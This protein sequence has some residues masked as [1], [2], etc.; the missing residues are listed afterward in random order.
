MWEAELNKT[1]IPEFAL[2]KILQANGMAR[3]LIREKFKQ[4]RGLIENCDFPEDPKTKTLLSDLQGF[5]DMIKIQADKIGDLF[6]ALEK[7]KQNDWKEEQLLQKR[8][9]APKKKV[10]PKTTKPA[11]SSRFKDFLAKKKGSK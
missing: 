11:V 2:E 1:G 9:A 10:A 5:W 4:F 3:L 7:L 8:K 6:G